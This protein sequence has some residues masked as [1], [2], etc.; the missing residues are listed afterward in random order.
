MRPAKKEQLI[1]FIYVI[2]CAVSFVVILSSISESGDQTIFTSFT[3]SGTYKD[4]V[5]FSLQSLGANFVDSVK[6]DIEENAYRIQFS[7]DGRCVGT[8]AQN[9]LIVAFCNPNEKQAFVYDSDNTF[10]SPDSGLCVGLRQDST[11]E[12]GLYLVPCEQAIQLELDNEKLTRAEGNTTLCLSALKRKNPSSQPDLGTPITLSECNEMTHA[13][14]LLEETEFLKD[15]AALM[16]PYTPSEECN[17]P[18]CAINTTPPKAQVVYP[19]RQR[20]EDIVDCVTVIV[21]TARRPLQVL[22]LAKSLEDTLNRNLSIVVIDDGPDLHPPEVMAKIAEHPNIKY[23]ISPD[24]DLG[25]AEG[26][27]LGVRTVETKY[28][29]NYDDDLVVSEKT[30]ITSMF[31]MMETLDASLVGG[32][33]GRNFAGFMHF[34]N[35]KTTGN[36]IME[37]Y[38]GSCA[39][40]SQEIPSFPGCYRC[41]LTTNSF[42]A[43]TKD[44][45]EVGGWSR[46]LKIK[47]H[48]DMF[49][50][51]KAAG[52]KVVYCKD[53]TIKNVHSEVGI[54]KVNQTGRS[55]D[56]Q[57]YKQLR[58][59]RIGQ[60]TNRFANHWN[61]IKTKDI[62]GGSKLKLDFIT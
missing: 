18:A 9:E 23:I 6:E 10:R 21:K 37:F 44:M 12:M 32:R 27:N 5:G 15:R 29:I 13:L 55:Y 20:C 35:D 3:F 28:F 24:E 52:K 40:E 60:M 8:S 34:A 30:N 54:D 19:P 36:P 45:L 59:K 43:R 22:R 49:L 57:A 56:R 25:I 48:K 31:E 42:M 4:V 47:E 51:L 38:P 50:R 2:V 14:Q 53:F 58:I 41:D 46:E 62:K 16:L 17:F 61:I 11:S 39:V 26:R 33:A 7:H 1:R